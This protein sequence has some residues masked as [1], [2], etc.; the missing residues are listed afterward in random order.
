MQ[1]EKGKENDTST[2]L[3]HLAELCLTLGEREGGNLPVIT[4]KKILVSPVPFRPEYYKK[5][6]GV[7]MQKPGDHPNFRK[8]TSRSE[9]A[10]LGALGAFRGILG[11]ALGVQKIILGMQNPILGVASHDLCNTKNAILEAT[12]GA[13]LG[14]GGNP[15]ERFSYAREFSERFSKIW[16]GPRAPEQFF[17]VILFV[18]I[19]KLI[20]ARGLFCNPPS[21][22]TATKYKNNSTPHHFMRSTF[23][24][25]TKLIL[26]KHFFLKSCLCNHF[27]RNGKQKIGVKT[28]WVRAG[29]IGEVC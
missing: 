5:K 27:G 3:C 18:I 14:I 23:E 21:L 25:I 28:F 19:A 26:P 10:I 17:F 8:K 22:P 29:K 2:F 20:L 7:A 11:A 12:P 1:H 13:I 6:F 4:H 15:R 16:G 24:I 9:K